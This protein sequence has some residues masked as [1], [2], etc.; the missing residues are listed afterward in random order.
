[1]RKSIKS[2]QFTCWLW[3]FDSRENDPRQYYSLK[4]LNLGMHCTAEAK[5]E[6]A[7]SG[8]ELAMYAEQIPDVE[9]AKQMQDVLLAK[10]GSLGQGWFNNSKM[11]DT[12]SEIQ[13]QSVGGCGGEFRVALAGDH[14][15]APLLL[16]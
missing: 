2:A 15:V 16:E 11:E 1:M 10:G 8:I 6:E 4:R 7:S 12:C 14:T 13:K 9:L 3:V 5:T